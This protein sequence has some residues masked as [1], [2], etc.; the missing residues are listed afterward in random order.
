MRLYA[1]AACA[2]ALL[3]TA[4]GGGDSAGKGSPV[5]A[6]RR[7]AEPCALAPDT[8]ALFGVA[9]EGEKREPVG[10]MAGNCRWDGPNGAIFAEIVIYTAGSTDRWASEGAEAFATRMAEGWTATSFQPA[11]PIEGVADGALLT[12]MP[13]GGVNA[14]VRKGDTVVFVMANS[15]DPRRSSEAIARGLVAAVAPRL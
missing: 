15:I 13:N 7:I 5:A 14:F 2:L 11:T 8:Q 10:T 6:Q 1:F 4:C 9:I 12:P 3:L